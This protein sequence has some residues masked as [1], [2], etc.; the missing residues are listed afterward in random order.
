MNYESKDRIINSGDELIAKVDQP[1]TNLI[2][3]RAYNKWFTEVIEFVQ[4]HAPGRFD[5]F[6]SIHSKNQTLFIQTPLDLPSIKMNLT[7][8]I[9][10]IEGS[11][12]HTLHY[13]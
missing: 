2:I 12:D 4:E 1:I 11:S 8:Q 13:V 5:E 9:A 6:E 7:I 10:I 3:L